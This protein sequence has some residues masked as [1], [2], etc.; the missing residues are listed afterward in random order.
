MER[1]PC[2]AWC[3]WSGF[4][5]RAVGLCSRH[6]I[7]AISIYG[8]NFLWARGVY[9]KRDRGGVVRVYGAGPPVSRLKY[10]KSMEWG[11]VGSVRGSKG[12]AILLIDNVSVRGSGYI[13]SNHLRGV[14]ERADAWSS[15][16]EVGPR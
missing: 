16:R 8:V 9:T 12:G 6:T 14:Y 10:A 4:P 7:G 1:G 2:S 5:L 13:W 3:R 11:T 15:S